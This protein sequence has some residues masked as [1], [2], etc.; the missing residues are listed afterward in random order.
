MSTMNTISTM[1]N[2]FAAIE[3]TDTTSFATVD[4]RNFFT[5]MKEDH[6]FGCGVAVGAAVATPIT[7]VITKKTTEKKINDQWEKK[8]AA[9]RKERDAEAA[10]IAAATRNSVYQEWEEKAKAAKAGR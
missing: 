4:N 8:L 10:N 1:N 3:N 2:S 9:Y 6:P 7:H 5:R